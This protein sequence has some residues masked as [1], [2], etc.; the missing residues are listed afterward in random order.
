MPKGRKRT[1]EDYEREIEETA[2]R[3]KAN[4]E[5]L[6]SAR[7]NSVWYDFLDGIGIDIHN[8]SP[9]RVGF[10]EDVRVAI[11]DKD[12]K[13]KA[14]YKEARKVGMPSKLARRIRDWSRDRAEREMERWQSQ[15]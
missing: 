14:L 7:N 1:A 10:F 2:K 5:Y 11:G 9:S 12:E 8:A 6:R 3:M 13:R 15:Y 4:P